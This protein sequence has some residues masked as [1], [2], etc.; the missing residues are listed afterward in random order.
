M[1][2]V[3]KLCFFINLTILPGCFQVYNDDED[4]RTV[5][6]TNNPNIVPNHSTAFM[7][8]TY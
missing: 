2:K 1:R 5:P 7:P 4:L 8:N 6:T 3:L